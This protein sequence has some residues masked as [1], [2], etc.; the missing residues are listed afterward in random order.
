MEQ[1]DA[2]LTHEASTGSADAFEAAVLLKRS[3][4]AARV[5]FLQYQ[6]DPHHGSL[7]GMTTWISCAILPGGGT[8][9]KQS[10][11]AADIRAI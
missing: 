2:G 9:G 11:L 5:G 4:D 1:V 8:V 6:R 10:P 7:S 3:I